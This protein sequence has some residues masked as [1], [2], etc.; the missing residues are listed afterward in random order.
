EHSGEGALDTSSPAAAS[1]AAAAAATAT[2]S[3]KALLAFRKALLAFRKALLILLQEA[4]LRSRNLNEWMPLANVHWP[5]LFSSEVIGL[6]RTF[7]CNV[8]VND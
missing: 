2:L 8:V 1:T 7:P 3:Q 5:F 4:R 6:S